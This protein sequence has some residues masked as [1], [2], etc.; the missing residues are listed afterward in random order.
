[1]QTD[2]IIRR[3]DDLG[4]IV[5]PREY[6]RLYAIDVGDPMEISAREGEILI[7]KVDINAEV[8]KNARKILT[9]ALKKVRGT[10]LVYSK[11]KLLYYCGERVDGLVEQSPDAVVDCM[12]KLS[13]IET[14][15]KTFCQ[16]EGINATV[17]PC[18][19]NG[20][21]YGAIAHIYEGK[22]SETER[23]IVGLCASVIA[24]FMQKY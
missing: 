18:H 20:D 2:G 15:G 5:I 7:K 16:R 4:R 8:T 11:F 3:I 22:E 13:P 19:G 14:D 1:M 24:E 12:T 9:S 6:R 10:L 21:C 17:Y 23:A